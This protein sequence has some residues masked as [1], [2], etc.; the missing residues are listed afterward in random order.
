M[1]PQ[2]LTARLAD[3]FVHNEKFTQFQFELMSPNQFEFTAGQYVSIAVSDLGYR[4]SYSMVSTPDNNHGFE[5]LVD[6]KIDGVGTNY[7]RDLKFGQ[8]IKALGPMGNF[9]VK[10]PEDK[11]IPLVFIATGSGIAP[12]RSMLYDQLQKH[13]LERPMTIYWG[14]RHESEMCWAEDLKDMVARF[15]NV[16][17]HPVISQAL[18][19]WPLCRGR[20]TACLTVHDLDPDA[21]YYVCGNAPMI[22]D[23][24]TVLG[25][26]GIDP[27]KVFHEKFY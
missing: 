11:T 24:K 5:L 15:P 2:L 23:V 22:Q 25:S 21:E 6:M 3:K 7:L 26:R 27:T 14:L 4:R 9:V 12:F 8:E 1:P 17:F 16:T 18:P 19:E 13:G 10:S 20:V